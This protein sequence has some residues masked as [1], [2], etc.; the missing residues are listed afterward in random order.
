MNTMRDAGI[1]QDFDRY[2]VLF[3]QAPMCIHEIDTDGRLLSMNQAGLDLVGVNDEE[4]VL[5]Q[6]Y[7]DFVAPSERNRIQRLM[8][9]AFKGKASE[10]EFL[11]AVVAPHKRYFS[12]CFIPCPNRDGEITRLIGLSSDITVRR[13]EAAELLRLNLTYE[14]LSRCNCDLARSMDEDDLLNA[15]CSNL[16]EIG[17]YLFSWINYSPP[18]EVNGVRLKAYAGEIDDDSSLPKVTWSADECAQ[19]AC[20][21]AVWSGQPMVLHDLKSEPDCVTC[22]KTAVRLGARSMIALPLQAERQRI[23]SLCIFSSDLDAF[24]EKEIALLMELAENLAIGIHTARNRAAR[25]QEV[26]RLR[27]DVEQEERKRIAAILHD[28]VGQSVQA[29][30]LGLKKLRALG[31]RE[32]QQREVLMNQLIDETGAVIV[33]LRDVSQELRPCCLERL[34]L[35]DAI[36]YHCRE[37]SKRT[38]V[39]IQ[40]VEYQE[41][42][43][44]EER[45]KAQCFLCFREAINNALKHAAAT[46]IDVTLEKQESGSLALR[47]EDDGVGFDSEEVFSLP[48][49]LGLAMISERAESVGG[50]AEIH[51]MPGQGTSI[52]IM[53]PFA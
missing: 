41:P 48:T 9:N 4:Q 26:R 7:L 24:C 23:G 47:V 31:N 32:L 13:E 30:N 12:S 37:Q 8:S 35:M 21:Q 45:V 40:A 52:T 14:M 29:V 33:D 17:G 51:S 36:S 49:G 1:S 22:K 3:E 28:G 10:F 25:K 34:D 38:D 42:L 53:V 43:R 18:C 6:P 16:V 2:R 15:F 11:V 5:G 20:G 50:Y 19:S 27:E 39:R 46:R 44:L